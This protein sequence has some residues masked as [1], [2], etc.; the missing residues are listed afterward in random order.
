MIS[1]SETS[2]YL[3][4]SLRFGD[5]KGMCI[6]VEGI[7][8]VTAVMLLLYLRTKYIS[9]MKD[10]SLFDWFYQYAHRDDRSICPTD[11]DYK[12]E[13]L[14]T[15]AERCRVVVVF[16]CGTVCCPILCKVALTFSKREILK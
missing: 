7:Y 16:P 15:V 6:Y 12:L 2:I 10:N 4:H 14:L 9:Q 8:D 1:R 13:C 11:V 5:V 3:I